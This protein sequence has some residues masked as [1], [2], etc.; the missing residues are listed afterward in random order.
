MVFSEKPEVL[1]YKTCKKEM[2]KHKVEKSDMWHDITNQGKVDPKKDPN[3]AICSKKELQKDYV[4]CR[5]NSNAHAP[6]WNMDNLLE[7]CQAKHGVDACWRCEFLSKG[8]FKGFTC[9]KCSEHTCTKAT[10]ICKALVLN[11]KEQWSCEKD[12]REE[13][14]S[15]PEKYNFDEKSGRCKRKPYCESE[16]SAAK[17]KK[18]NEKC[19][20]KV[21]KDNKQHAAK[22]KRLGEVTAINVRKD[23]KKSKGKGGGNRCSD[24]TSFEGV[25]KLPFTGCHIANLASKLKLAEFPLIKQVRCRP[26]GKVCEVQKINACTDYSKSECAASPENM[27]LTQHF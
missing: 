17:G 3:N 14:G 6:A 23:K 15:C 2:S 24:F 13:T 18:K 21:K 1:D 22:G 11:T 9:S 27:I 7:C 26:D 16:R 8:G 10:T 19:D 20:K 4:N 5:A 12:Y 25:E